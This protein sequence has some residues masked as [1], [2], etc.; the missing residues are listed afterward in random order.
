VSME[1]LGRLQLAAGS[2]GPGSSETDAGR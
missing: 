2:P 1:M